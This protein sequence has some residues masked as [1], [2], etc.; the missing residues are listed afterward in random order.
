MFAVV[1]FPQK[2]FQGLVEQ[3]VSLLEF[4]TPDK[5]LL[6]CLDGIDELLE[7]NNADLSW[8][9]T[10]LPKNVYFIVSTCTESGFSRLQ[11]LEVKLCFI[12]LGRGGYSTSPKA[13]KYSGEV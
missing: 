9:P 8:I 4:A 5:P 2:D 10:E 1:F 6:I 12:A 11:E 3:F 7:E 13:V